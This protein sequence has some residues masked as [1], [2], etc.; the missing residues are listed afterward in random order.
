MQISSCLSEYCGVVV[1]WEWTIGGVGR[2]APYCMVTV[3]GSSTRINRAICGESRHHDLTGCS[4]SSGQSSKINRSNDTIRRGYH[5]RFDIGMSQSSVRVSTSHSGG[6]SAAQ[7]PTSM[8][9]MHYN[10]IS[11]D[12]SVRE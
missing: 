11:G 5:D 9:I 2:W 8:T 7:V 12:W 4:A 6:M 3:D 10:D 1:T